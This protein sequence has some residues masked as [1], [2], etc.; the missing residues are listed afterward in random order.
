[1]S[2][3]GESAHVVPTQTSHS[4]RLRDCAYKNIMMDPTALY[5]KGFHPESPLTLL[6][7]LTTYAPVLPRASV[8]VTYYYIDFGISTLFTCDDTNRLVTG[9]AGLDK[10]VPELSDVVAYDP[11]KVDVFILGNLFRQSFLQVCS[12]WVPQNNC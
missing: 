12:C 1:M 11:F 10:G 9:R 7:D 5:P 3:T 4:T 8:P 6:N 2:R